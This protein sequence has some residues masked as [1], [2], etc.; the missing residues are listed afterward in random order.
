[1]TID[2]GAL[3]G[4]ML[5]SLFGAFAGAFLA[6]QFQRVEN[7]RLREIE[8]GEGLINTLHEKALGWMNEA[9]GALTPADIAFRLKSGPE[10]VRL[11]RE[12][13]LDQQEAVAVEKLADLVPALML[14]I[15]GTMPLEARVTVTQE[16]MDKISDQVAV[17]RR[18]LR[19]RTKARAWPFGR[20]S[21]G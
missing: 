17:L 18:G 10:I 5:G 8:V 21:G 16:A 11:M 19:A 15:V 1:V 9:A 2:L 3:L 4:T 14:E 20:R 12:L 7:E 6:Y 13:D